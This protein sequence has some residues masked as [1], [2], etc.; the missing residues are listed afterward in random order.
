MQVHN[1]QELIR[2]R[3]CR[4][5]YGDWFFP[6]ILSMRVLTR[7]SLLEFP[8][9]PLKLY[10]LLPLCFASIKGHFWPIWIGGPSAPTKMQQQA[11]T[12]IQKGTKKRHQRFQI[13]LDF[14]WDLNWCPYWDILT[15]TKLQI[16]NNLIDLWSIWGRHPI[17]LHL[18]CQ[19]TSGINSAHQTAKLYRTSDSIRYMLRRNNKHHINT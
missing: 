15:S 16:S 9:F 6:R 7:R 13:L 5:Q 18:I 10:N 8:P 17:Q 4:P 12:W 19:L 11:L 2:W 1:T 14:S 3:R